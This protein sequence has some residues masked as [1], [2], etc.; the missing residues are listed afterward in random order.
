MAGSSPSLPA[1]IS[2]TFKQTFCPPLRADNMLLASYSDR[3]GAHAKDASL[4]CDELGSECW[5]LLYQRLGDSIFGHLLQ[6]CSMFRLVSG[7][8]FLQ[9]SGPTV[10]FKHLTVESANLA[11]SSS[12]VFERLSRSRDRAESNL[13]S[14]QNRLEEWKKR[15]RP[16]EIEEDTDN[17][18]LPP[19]VPPPAKQRCPYPI[20]YVTLQRHLIYYKHPKKLCFGLPVGWKAGQW[21]ADEVG[22][23]ALA[24]WI[25]GTTEDYLP[26]RAVNSLYFF[27]GILKRLKRL[28]FKSILDATCPLAELDASS[29]DDE[30]EAS[31]KESPVVSRSI[32]DSIVTQTASPSRID[33]PPSSL[34]PLPSQCDFPHMA[35]SGV[36]DRPPVSQKSQRANITVTPLP[37]TQE[38]DM[39][40][41]IDDAPENGLFDSENEDDYL[42]YLLIEPTANPV[43]NFS[44]PE[45]LPM[46]CRHHQVSRFVFRVI[47]G[48]IPKVG[49]GSDENWRLLELKIS[50]F[51]S[52]N[53]YDSISTC[54]LLDGFKIMQIPWLASNPQSKGP[55]NAEELSLRTK[56]FH[57][58]LL[59]LFD[60]VIIP[61]L[62]TTFY[63]TETM[64]HR[65]QMFFYR[66]EVWTRINTLGFET[67]I[68]RGVL[69]AVSTDDAKF[70]LQKRELGSCHIRFLP[71]KNGVRPIVNMKKAHANPERPDPRSINSFLQP[72][73]SILTYE[74]HSSSKNLLASSLLTNDEVH[75]QLLGFKR[76]LLQLAPDADLPT[77]PL[78]KLPKLYLVKT[79]IVS[80][81]DEINQELLMKI[82]EDDVVSAERYLAI[83]T[84]KI[85]IERERL[86]VHTL[87][88]FTQA[89]PERDRSLSEILEVQGGKQ[90]NSVLAKNMRMGFADRSSMLAI[91]REHI[92]RHLIRFNGKFFLQRCGIPQGSTLS[93]LLC[94]LYFAHLEKTKLSHLLQD[95]PEGDS[96]VP[97]T[98]VLLRWIDDFLFISTDKNAAIEFF[99]MMHAG[100]QDYGTR[101]NPNKSQ[102]NFDLR[103]GETD[104]SNV[105]TQ[106]CTQYNAEDAEGPSTSGLNEMIWCG[107][108]I[109]TR[110]LEF[111]RV[112]PDGVIASQLISNNLSFRPGHSISEKLHASLRNAIYPLLFDPRFNSRQV[113]LESAFD[114]TCW[115]ALRLVALER[116][117]Q[118]PRSVD[119]KKPRKLTNAKFI[120]DLI[121]SLVQCFHSTLNKKSISAKRGDLKYDCPLHLKDITMTTLLA[122]KKMLSR[123]LPLF[124]PVTEKLN[125]LLADNSAQCSN[126]KMQ[127]Y[128]KAAS[129]RFPKFQGAIF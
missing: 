29:D 54:V 85:K 94:S 43:A 23:K 49:F 55:Y 69:R 35:S 98:S 105:S 126:A 67:L 107:W 100:F 18:I 19:E 24:S 103:F 121:L 56:I 60:S 2:T 84:T 25:F 59:W 12:K 57:A 128:H 39:D 108:L 99:E 93:S 61:L 27:R 46:F 106:P 52:L 5:S 51:I 116:G 40:Y 50:K 119:L 42:L 6:R 87:R 80:A 123:H 113:L 65:N 66:R 11:K 95:S 109:N 47:Q 88:S 64:M 122:F 89:D 76:R 30:A 31:L 114:V 36:P 117:A 38:D 127:D 22:A 68:S 104:I 1:F 111:R 8:N 124:Q 81:F 41:G 62:G 118:C 45:L 75:R 20:S 78:P 92:T 96:D 58:F 17:S 125:A 70:A 77:D 44:L 26:R 16:E 63:V 129:N 53:R 72:I 79:D 7:F 10:T 9:L 90:T 48:L 86:R 71:K 82:L 101:C 120:V 3:R 14:H 33:P 91:L 115:T 32:H 15:K 97:R 74:A 13:K 4:T 34:I 83:L 102:V 110:T 37:D 112:V 73:H 28:H 21:N